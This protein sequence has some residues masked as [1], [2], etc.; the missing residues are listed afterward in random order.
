VECYHCENGIRGVTPLLH[1]IWTGGSQ[2]EPCSVEGGAR[3][4]RADASRV[5]HAHAA[6]GGPVNSMTGVAASLGQPA[7]ANA[8]PAAAADEMAQGVANVA[9]LLQ[10]PCCP[11]VQQLWSP[12][13]QQVW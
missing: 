11:M 7:A 13:L 12:M 1:K 6:V 8:F 3:A 5:G 9:P 2:Y 10:Q 4:I